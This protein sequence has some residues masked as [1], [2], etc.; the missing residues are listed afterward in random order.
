MI[1]LLLLFVACA[2][3]SAA[4]KDERPAYQLFDEKGKRTSYQKLRRA[5]AK[6]DVVL[7][8][9]FHNNTLVHWLQLQ[10][11]KDLHADRPGQV[12]LGAEMLEADNQLLFD[13]YQQGLIAERHLEAE[14]K[15]W[16]NYPTDYKPLVQWATAQGVPVVAT[17][18]PRRYAALVARQGLAA[19]DSLSENVR[20]H[21]APLPLTV[22][23]ELPAYQKMQTMMGGH[24]E[25][26]AHGG[27]SAR[28][29]VAAQALKDA[30]M[31]HFILRD[32]QPGQVVLH[33]NGSYHSDGFEGIG[34]YLQQA[35]PDLNVLT[36][37]M[38]EQTDLSALD[39]AA[40]GIAHFVFALPDDMTKSY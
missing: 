3:L 25:G 22:D 36:I 39:T 17:N 26:G 28:Q 21:M 30:T 31:A 6:A 38:V 9:E 34:W 13:E 27:A 7:F 32:H 19:L 11:L 16:N 1:R 12:R 2:I 24:G 10:L 40:V 23:Y 20:A 5:A 8:G 35:R 37:S 33:L 14:A 29:M 4:T 15:L 18:V